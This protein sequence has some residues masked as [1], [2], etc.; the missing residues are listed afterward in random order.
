MEASG[1]LFP[2]SPRAAFTRTGEL[3]GKALQLSISTVDSEMLE[4][5]HPPPDRGCSGTLSPF[6]G[7]VEDE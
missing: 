1:T 7:L 4:E 6:P 5:S 2:K 3:G